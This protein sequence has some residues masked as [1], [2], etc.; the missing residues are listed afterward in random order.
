[1]SKFLVTAEELRSAAR[2]IEQNLSE[3]QQANDAA[4]NAGMN[5]ASAWEGDAQK[6]FV[7]EQEK[8]KQWYAQMNNVVKTYVA[9]LNAAAAAYEAAEA[10]AKA[11]ITAG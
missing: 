4:L 10:A 9:A 6:A 5:L 1:M 8:V 11:I 2:K 7:Q 3:Y